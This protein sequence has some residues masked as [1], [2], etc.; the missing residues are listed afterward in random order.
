MKAVGMMLLLVGAMTA[1]NAVPA[2]PEID[3]GSAASAVA[4]LSGALLVLRSRRKK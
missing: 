1:A 4:L 2:A 3:G